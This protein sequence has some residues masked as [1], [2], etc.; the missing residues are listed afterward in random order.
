MRDTERRIVDFL[1]KEKKPVSMARL[2]EEAGASHN[3]REVAALLRERILREY[4]ELPK[5]RPGKLDYPDLTDT[6]KY[7]L[8]KIIPLLEKAKTPVRLDRLTE[9]LRGQSITDRDIHYVLSGLA[10]HGEAIQFFDLNPRS[11][12]GICF[13]HDECVK[14]KKKLNPWLCQLF[15]SDWREAVEGEVSKHA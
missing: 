8:G 9:E 12:C 1:G 6:E 10:R 3:G 7:N 11:D 2:E 15:V 13:Y 5:G 14:A 4:W